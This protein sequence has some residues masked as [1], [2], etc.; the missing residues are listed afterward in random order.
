MK[1]GN[2]FHIKLC[3]L[4]HDSTDGLCTGPKQQQA[5]GSWPHFHS[6][7][8]QQGVD[9]QEILTF[10]FRG[11]T[12]LKNHSQ[13]TIL[14]AQVPCAGPG[15]SQKCHKILQR[16]LPQVRMHWPSLDSTG[17]W[18]DK[19]GG[20]EKGGKRSGVGGGLLHWGSSQRSL[21]KVR[22]FGSYTS[23]LKCIGARNLE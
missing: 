20:E 9:I 19:E 7:L 2:I 23:G 4:L 13:G 3:L 10:L 1:Q 14:S 12:E 8:P 17:A 21:L 15:V 5:Q 18:G 16:V 22:T 6:C 11:S